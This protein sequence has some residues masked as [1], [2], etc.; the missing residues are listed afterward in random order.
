ME[1][2]GPSKVRAQKGYG[3]HLRL[4]GALSLSLPV[5]L[6]PY[7]PLVTSCYVER[8]NRTQGK[9]QRPASNYI[10]ELGKGSP[11]GCGSHENELGQMFQFQLNLEMPR[12]LISLACILV[13]FSGSHSF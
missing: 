2:D 10:V 11:K 3:F 8:T 13:R 6:P 9:V 1:W 5:F 12:V 7:L 4:P